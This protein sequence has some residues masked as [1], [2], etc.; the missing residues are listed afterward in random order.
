MSKYKNAAPKIVKKEQSLTGISTNRLSNTIGS[1]INTSLKHVTFAFDSNSG[2]SVCTIRTDDLSRRLTFSPDMLCVTH[3]HS[4]PITDIQYNMFNQSVMATTGYDAQIQLWSVQDTD[5]AMHSVSVNPLSSI[6]LN[7]SR[8]DCIQWN[9]N[10]DKVL[11]ST[12]LNTL[13][14]WDVSNHAA[15]VCA[16]RNHQEAIQGLSWKRDGSLLVTTAKDKTMQIVDPRNMNTNENLRIENAKTANKDSKV[17]WVGTSNCILASVYSQ[18]HQRELHL[19][20]IRNTTEPVCETPIDM[21]NNVLTPLF[22]HDTSMLFL[23][24]KA[25]TLVRY[26]EVF[27]SDSAP[28]NI[29]CNSAQQVDDQIKAICMVP[30]FGLDLMKCEID[31]L[32]LLTRNSVYPLPYFVPRRSYYDFHADVFPD[33]YNVCEPGLGKTEW[34]QGTNSEPV[35]VSLNPAQQKR[36]FTSSNDPAPSVSQ[37]PTPSATTE[38]KAPAAAAAAKP[39]PGAAAAAPA[40]SSTPAVSSLISNLNKTANSAATESN[41]NGNGGGIKSSGPSLTTSS[42]ED[43]NTSSTSS[44]ATPV[45]RRAAFNKPESGDSS[46]SNGNGNGVRASSNVLKNS[47]TNTSAPADRK[48]K[49]KSVYYQSKFKYINGKAAH[50][51]DHI[52]NIRNLS[53]MWPSECN[54]FQINSKHAAFLLAGSSGQIGVVE[55]NKPGRL[56]DTTIFSIVNK[57]KVSDF[58]WDPFDD[59]T[60]AAACDDGIIK[61]WKIPADGLDRSLEEPDIELRGHLERLYCIQYHPYAKNV[62]ATASY[63]RTIKIWNIDTRQAEIT[64]KGHTDVIFNIS[65]SLDGTKLA[66]ICKDGFIRVYEPLV[67]DEPIVASK[68]GPAAGSKAAR[69]EWVLNDASLL[70]SGFGRGNLRQLFL[71]ESDTLSQMHS[72][73]INQS[74]SLLI[75]YYDSDISVLY[76]YAKGEE[77]LYLYEIQE[78]APYFQALT[79]F[80][81]EGLHFAIAFLPK[82]L[83]DVKAAEISKAYR[84]TKDNRIEPMSFTVPRVKLGFFQDDIYPDTIDRH[85]PYLM[86]PDW[87]SG[88]KVELNYI[89]LQPR[90]MQRLTDMQANE[91]VVPQV[92]PAK[93][94]IPDKKTESSKGD[95]YNPENLNDDERKIINSMLHRATL[96]YKEKSDEENDENSDWN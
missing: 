70:V 51:N 87:F 2:G 81:P 9:P 95:M 42:N 21:G 3:A 36:Y 28:W 92:K 84:L 52:T 80:K 53:T 96:F 77:T 35:K 58:A 31:R 83:C 14:L 20:D 49:V 39:A 19:W 73:D 66:T 69:I 57:A 34:L 94:F 90:D 10:I 54:G 23:N 11:A 26:C 63:D 6:M 74:P 1:L 56:A 43:S 45:M 48:T 78:D 22:D 41:G 79:P 71:F 32:L 67:S 15:P 85:I 30:K 37:T 47:N 40:A 24:G 5:N 13:Y 76:L 61:I 33:T 29:Q 50:R 59:E 60:L 89:N 7:E 88:S 8:S 27:L 62:I 25:E 16:L 91:P 44:N 72:E 38:F 12:S 18:S 65:W 17:V 86:A 55:L 93:K 82:I 46:A 75:P 4:G 68:C 64:L